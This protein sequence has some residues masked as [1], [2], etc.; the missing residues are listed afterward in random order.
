MTFQTGSK[1]STI[2]AWSVEH[3]S[4]VYNA[5]VLQAVDPYHFQTTAQSQQQAAP[6]IPMTTQQP[7]PQDTV[8]K[9]I[10]NPMG[11]LVD[12]LFH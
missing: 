3:Y 9:I 5:T 6:P 11:A 12:G 4:G 8:K 2:A 7:R 1:M 10:N